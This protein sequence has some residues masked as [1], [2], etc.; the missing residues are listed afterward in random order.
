M[1]LMSGILC[2]KAPAQ[3]IAVKTNLLDDASLNVNL[4][5]EVRL[6]SKWSAEVPVSLNFWNV[7]G[8]KWKHWHVSPGVRYWFCEAF[9]GHFLGI[10]AIG[11]QYNIGNI[12][13]P[14]NLLG[15]D[16]RKLKDNRYEGWGIGAGISYGYSWILGRHWNLEA[17]LGVGYVW[18]RYSRFECQGCGRKVESGKNHH[19][20]GPTRLAVNLV[21][22]F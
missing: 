8:H 13:I 3:N 20:V 22:V 18:S 1:M 16:F 17:E 5:G 12:D 14:V 15:T 6:A 21:Y 9:A 2:I 7:D 10:H 19:Y 11:T 4:G